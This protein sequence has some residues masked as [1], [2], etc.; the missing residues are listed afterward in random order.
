[1]VTV[2]AAVIIVGLGVVE[3]SLARGRATPDHPQE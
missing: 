3:R 1:M 2:L